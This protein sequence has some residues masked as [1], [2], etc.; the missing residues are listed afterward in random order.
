M[1]F[2]LEFRISF[3]EF[4]SWIREL[5]LFAAIDRVWVLTVRFHDVSFCFRVWVCVRVMLSLLHDR[6]VRAVGQVHSVRLGFGNS[7]E[8]LVDCS[9]EAYWPS[10]VSFLIL[11]TL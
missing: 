10:Q 4:S 2:F 11:D 8:L 5:V 3:V 9:A 6:S 7:I 1:V